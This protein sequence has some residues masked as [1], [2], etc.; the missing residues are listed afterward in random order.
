MLRDSE[1]KREGHG[2]LSSMLYIPLPMQFLVSSHKSRNQKSLHS[3]Y[4][5]DESIRE[6]IMQSEELFEIL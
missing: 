3:W 5:D 4:V 6:D 1:L 2:P